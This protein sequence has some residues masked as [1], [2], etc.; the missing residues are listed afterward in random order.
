MSL[1]GSDI[2][3]GA[4]VSPCGAYR[5]QL[6]RVWDDSLPRVLFVMLNPST[7]D[8]ETDDPTIRKCVKYAK[9]WGYGSLEVVNL[10]ALR[11]TDPNKLLKHEAPIPWPENDQYILESA[12][13]SER[14][15]AAWSRHKAVTVGARGSHVKALLSLHGFDLYCLRTTKAGQPWHPLYVPDAQTPVEFHMACRTTHR[16]DSAL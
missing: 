12:Y 8:A 6:W 4:T 13:R 7:A 5:Y 15:M 2:Q 10:F 11:S 16:R 3:K 1:F 14:I 9:A